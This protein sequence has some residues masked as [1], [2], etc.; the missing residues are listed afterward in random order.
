MVLYGP[1]GTPGLALYV[2]PD[3]QGL[4]ISDGRGPRIHLSNNQHDDTP[5]SELIFHDEQK[6]TQATLRGGRGGASLNLY[7]P[8][9]ER[10]FQAP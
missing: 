6:G 1:R 3:S 4:V 2:E 10:A 5:L 7:R 9:G 8:N